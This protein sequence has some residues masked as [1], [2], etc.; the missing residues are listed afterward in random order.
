MRFTQ[1]NYDGTDMKM[2]VEEPIGSGHPSIHPNLRTL[3]TDTYVFEPLAFGD[4]TT[5]IRMVDLETGEET[6]LCRMHTE[7][8]AQNGVN[9]ALRLDP[10]PA[11]TKDFNYLV[12]NG[13]DGGTRKVYIADMREIVNS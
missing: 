7:T 13:F 10:H 12:F 5:P 8:P 1:V 3:V 2:I 4:G 9:R 6:T 11:W